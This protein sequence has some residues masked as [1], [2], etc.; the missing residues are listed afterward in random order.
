LNQRPPKLSGAKV[1]DND[2]K[3]ASLG[4]KVLQER[5]NKD[6]RRE[7]ICILIR[8]NILGENVNAK[9]LGTRERC[10]ESKRT[11]STIGSYI[12]RESHQ[13]KGVRAKGCVHLM[14]GSRT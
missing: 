2:G 3:A 10:K 9:S 12:E 11:T 8:L 6:K 7:D 13:V 14:P 1:R 5:T 4:T